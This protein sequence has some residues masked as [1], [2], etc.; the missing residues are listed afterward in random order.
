M[1]ELRVE[2]ARHRVVNETESLMVEFQLL[3]PGEIMRG[4]PGGKT[5]LEKKGYRAFSVWIP[6]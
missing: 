4:A 6:S 5:G 3:F 1:T 2:N